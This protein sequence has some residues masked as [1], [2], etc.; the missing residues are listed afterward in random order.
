MDLTSLLNIFRT[1]LSYTGGTKVTR[2]EISLLIEGGDSVT[3]PII[4]ADLPEIKTTQNNDVFNSVIGDVSIMG[5]LG[6]REVNFDDF[7]LPNDVSKYSFSKGD[8]SATILN[9]IQDNHQK[10]QP[11]RLIMTK[12]DSTILNMSCLIDDYT[13]YQDTVGDTHLSITFKEYRV[14]NPTTGGLET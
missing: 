10:G 1:F 5:L 9:F 3:F 6:L 12:N 2:G 7:L 8:D 14:Y 13:Y 11:F 4:P